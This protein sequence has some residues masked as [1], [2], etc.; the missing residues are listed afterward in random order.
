MT[1]AFCKIAGC[2]LESRNRKNLVQHRLF[3]QSQLLRELGYSKFIPERTSGNV[4][5][6][7]AVFNC[8][9]A[10]LPNQTPSRYFPENFPNF[11][12]QFPNFFIC[13][14]KINYIK[15]YMKARRE[16][17]RGGRPSPHFVRIKRTQHLQYTR[18]RKSTK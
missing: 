15:N 13:V 18:R 10:T 4:Q 9:I 12:N 2:V 3:F 6:K 16:S 8:G 14:E 5:G 11:S 1:T 17:R 7:V